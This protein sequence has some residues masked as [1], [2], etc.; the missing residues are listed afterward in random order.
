M[1]VA[2]ASSCP[3][4][5]NRTE[6]PYAIRSLATSIECE[7]ICQK[8]S[9][10]DWRKSAA[11]AR[12]LRERSN[13]TLRTRTVNSHASTFPTPESWTRLSLRSRAPRPASEQARVN[14]Y[15]DWTGNSLGLVVSEEIPHTGDGEPEFRIWPR[16]DLRDDNIR[17]PK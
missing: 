3:A 13:S 9:N 1:P 6:N 14:T 5:S 7:L 12:P 11:G 15:T 8:V 4:L 10:I 2:G 17:R 16:P